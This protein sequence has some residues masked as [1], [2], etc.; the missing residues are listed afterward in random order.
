MSSCPVRARDR[1]RALSAS[2]RALVRGRAWAMM[3]GGPLQLPLLGWVATRGPLLGG[4]QGDW[5]GEV[6]S[7]SCSSCI[8]TFFKKSTQRQSTTFLKGTTGL[9]QCQADSLEF[10]T[11]AQQ[12]A[13]CKPMTADGVAKHHQIVLLSTSNVQLW[14]RIYA[15][16]SVCRSADVWLHLHSINLCICTTSCWSTLL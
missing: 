5:L 14:K 8:K 15:C 1:S 10:A 11:V 16:I 6:Y 12:R 13:Q 3:I 9:Q 4:L 7:R 2:V